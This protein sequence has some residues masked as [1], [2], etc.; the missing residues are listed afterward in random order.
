MCKHT[1]IHVHTNANANIEY[2]CFFKKQQL[3]QNWGSRYK[4]AALNQI[5]STYEVP[6]AGALYGD[7]GGWVLR[8]SEI[9]QPTMVTGK[10]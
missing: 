6:S 2:D 8:T 1:Y 5:S 7:C 4:F 9:H 10:P 3:S